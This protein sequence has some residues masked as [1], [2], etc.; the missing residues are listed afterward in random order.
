[1]QEVLELKPEM[2]WFRQVLRRESEYICGRMRPI[3]EHQRGDL[4]M[5]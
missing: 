2:K 3:A 1:M 4:W 5:K